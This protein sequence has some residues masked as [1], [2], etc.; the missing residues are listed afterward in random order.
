MMM[1]INNHYAIVMQSLCNSDACIISSDA[2][3][4]KHHYYIMMIQINHHYVVVMLESLC[5]S[6]VSTTTCANILLF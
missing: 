4:C 5:S 2:Y 3:R 1:G 6:D